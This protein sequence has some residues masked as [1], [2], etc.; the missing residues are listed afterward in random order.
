M[1]LAL[2]IDSTKTHVWILTKPLGVGALFAGM[3][4]VSPG[5]G[6][7]TAGLTSGPH[8]PG[9]VLSGSAAHRSSQSAVPSASLSM[10]TRN[11]LP[12]GLDVH[13]TSHSSSAC[14]AA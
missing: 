11:T 13:S 4:R 10:V 12:C 1:S 7:L 14:A 8:T 9:F 3:L 5:L 2:K 6:Y